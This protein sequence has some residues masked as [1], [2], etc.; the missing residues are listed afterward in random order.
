LLARNDGDPTCHG[1]GGA[2]TDGGKDSLPFVNNVWRLDDLSWQFCLQPSAEAGLAVVT[3]PVQGRSGQT[4]NTIKVPSNWTLQEGYDKPI[5]TNIKYPWPCQPPLVPHENP[6]GVYKVQFELP[7][8]D[9]DWDDYCITFHGVESAYYVYWNKEFVGFS[10]DS[11]L[12][13]EFNV[14]PHVKLGAT[15]TLEVVVLRWSDG[16]Y[17]EDQDQWWM[18]GTLSFRARSSKRLRAT[19]TSYFDFLRP[20]GR[21]SSISGAYS[22]TQGCMYYRLPDPG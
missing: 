8:K 9:T 20:F 17:V 7:W 14:T 3:E 21:D 6:T 12:P 13:S 2:T 4:W 18:A 15:N 1:T 10:K 5:Y 11:R 22:S 16:S 19:L